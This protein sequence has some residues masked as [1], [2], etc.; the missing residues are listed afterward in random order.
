M[1]SA[2]RGSAVRPRRISLRC[3]A[4]PLRPAVHGSGGRSAGFLPVPVR[5]V[6]GVG[7]RAGRRPG[8]RIRGDGAPS[9]R[10]PSPVGRPQGH[11]SPA[12]RPEGHPY[13]WPGRGTRCRSAGVVRR[14][15]E[16][17]ARAAG[18]ARPR[19][20]RSVARPVR[21]RR[22]RGAGGRSGRRPGGHVRGGAS[23]PRDPPLVSRP[24][25]HPRQRARRDACRVTVGGKI[26]RGSSAER[27]HAF[28]TFMLTFRL[29]HITISWWG[30]GINNTNNQLDVID[31]KVDNTNKQQSERVF[32]G[33]T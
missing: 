31:G 10:D 11:P 25:G 9:P 18:R 30:T 16:H 33:C 28:F 21:V 3:R 32:F 17:A 24:P 7:G 4:A 5:R 29:G 1:P 22:V 8:G 27:G 19:G 26:N 2:G 14:G 13:C 23:L 15:R 12:G 6:R 20:W